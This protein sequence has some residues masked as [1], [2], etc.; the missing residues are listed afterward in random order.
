VIIG[1]SL[2]I[3]SNDPGV[4][5]TYYGPWFPRGANAG[6]F[7]VEVQ[8]ASS[9]FTLVVTVQHKNT[10][11]TDASPGTAVVLPTVTS[12]D[13]EVSASSDGYLELMRYKYELSSESTAW[14]HMRMNPPLWQ[15][16]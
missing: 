12:P 5:T 3:I 9:A 6:T 11:D 2:L 10:E 14:I 8:Y 13:T 15:P 7:V 16:N 4:P 1:Q